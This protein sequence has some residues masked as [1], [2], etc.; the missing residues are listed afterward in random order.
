MESTAKLHAKRHAKEVIRTIHPAAHA[1]PEPQTLMEIKQAQYVNHKNTNPKI[2]F[3]HA[4][5]P[6]IHYN[7][8]L[9]MVAGYYR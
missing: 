9:Q 5:K 7:P 1:L 8:P 6:V 4:A 2:R 3:L